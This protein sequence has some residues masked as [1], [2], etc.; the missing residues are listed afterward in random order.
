MALVKDYSQHSVSLACTKIGN[1]KLVWLW[2][3]HWFPGTKLTANPPF[4]TTNCHSY[5]L[6]FILISSV[7]ENTILITYCWTEPAISQSL[8]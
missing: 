6:V 4:K 5:Y 1:G 3:R 2:S 7:F 8:S